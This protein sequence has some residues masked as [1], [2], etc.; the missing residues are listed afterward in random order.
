MKKSNSTAA[1]FM[2]QN[3]FNS[4][5]NNPINTKKDEILHIPF[6]PRTPKNISLALTRLN[7]EKGNINTFTQLVFTD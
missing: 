4:L 7:Q 2:T 6:A 1:Y 3:R 5:I